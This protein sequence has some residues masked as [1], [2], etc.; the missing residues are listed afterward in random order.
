MTIA[1]RNRFLRAGLI[2]AAIM[3]I[4]TCVAAVVV[5]TGGSL[6]KTAPGTR[7][8]PLLDRLPAAPYSAL[9][10]TL[11]I[12][13]FPIF[14]VITL[15]YVLFGFEKTQTIE[16]TFF[17]ATA[18]A[19]ALESFRILIPLLE[20]WNN[21]TGYAVEVSRIALFGRLL[22]MLTMLAG[23]IFV[24]GDNAQQT[25]AGIFILAFFA[26]TLAKAIPVNS[27]VLVS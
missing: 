17:A 22:A 13:V 1:A 20:L 10:S 21:T 3:M 25:G 12:V 26:F 15:G 9:A 16:L 14:S 19:M 11:A 5:L 6:P 7:V 4:L 23:I 8:L 24:T 27:A 18:F 2:L